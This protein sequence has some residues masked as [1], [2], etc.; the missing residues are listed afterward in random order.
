[1]KPPALA[2]E[3][4]LIIDLIKTRICFDMLGSKNCDHPACWALIDIIIDITAGAHKTK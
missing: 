4:D 1:M 3:R 2:N